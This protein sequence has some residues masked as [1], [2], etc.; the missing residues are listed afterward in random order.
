[1]NR[2][3]IA[4]LAALLLSGCLAS[5]GDVALLQTQLTSMSQASA[6]AAE[7]QRVLIDQVLAQIA[8]T[9]DSIRILSTRLARFQGDVQNE[10]F[11]A[12]RQMIQIQELVG[13]TNEFFHRDPHGRSL[14]MILCEQIPQ[15][16]GRLK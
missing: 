4:P 6:R 16:R 12:G 13:Q 7:A 2:A 1:M 9:N 3:R 10:H 5:K 14:H 11:E 15:L 8:R